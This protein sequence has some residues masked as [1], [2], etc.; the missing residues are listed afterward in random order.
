MLIKELGTAT[1]L[2]IGGGFGRCQLY[3]FCFLDTAF[4][5]VVRRRIQVVFS[6]IWDS[7]P[8]MGRRDVR[9]TV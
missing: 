8:R 7:Y 2:L 4:L 9:S 6:V 1:T 3:Y 5:R